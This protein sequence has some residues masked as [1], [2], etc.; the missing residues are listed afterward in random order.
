MFPPATTITKRFN[1]FP[2][3]Q[4]LGGTNAATLQVKDLEKS[5]KEIA[6]EVLP[7]GYSIAWG[8]RICKKKKLME[9][10]KFFLYICDYLYFFLILVALYE[11]WMIPWAIVFSRP[12]C[13]PRSRT[14]IW[15]RGLQNDI[16]FP[17]RTYHTGRT[18]S[19]KCH[20]N[21]RICTSKR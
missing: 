14:G 12:F 13:H 19:Q 18:F 2:S 16:Y 7:Q 11:S 9:K 5:W 1:M 15:L 8:R 20:L 4:I 21:G 6:A 3:A 17:N 10:R